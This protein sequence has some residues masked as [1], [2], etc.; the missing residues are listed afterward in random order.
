MK[1]DGA[2]TQAAAGMNL[3]N[4]Q[5]SERSQTQKAMWTMIPCV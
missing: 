2:L 5:L 3:E 4:I 1:R